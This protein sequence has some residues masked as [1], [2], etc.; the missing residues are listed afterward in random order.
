MELKPGQIEDFE[1]D[2]Y[3]VMKG[4]WSTEE[5]DEFV[6]YMLD[7]QAGRK[8]V[9]HYEPRHADDWERIIYRSHLEPH[10]LQWMVDP[11][12]SEPLAALLGG[13]AECI[14]GMYNFK[15]TEQRWHQDEYHLPGCIGAWSALVD[16]NANNGALEIQVGSHK[17]PA[18]DKADF[19]VDEHGEPGRWQGWEYEDV[20]CKF[21][22]QNRM[23]EVAIEAEKGDLIFF[24][25]RIIHRGGSILEPGSFRHS[26][27][28][29]YIP[30]SF[31]PWPYEE[32][33]RLRISFDRV[34]RFTDTGLE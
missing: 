11:R 8:R 19:R 9:L 24:H 13:E 3:V 10:A 2:G 27:V 22:R 5:C 12:L 7:L 15:G 25:R 28:S 26:F 17:G 30:K 21:V 31:D 4:A 18:A 16:V 1:R 33:P 6:D 23:P 29:H 32:A 34:C 20:F 14:Q